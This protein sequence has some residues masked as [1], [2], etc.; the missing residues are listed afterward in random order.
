[1]SD[2]C[3]TGGPRWVNTVVPRP[4]GCLVWT[5]SRSSLR[6]SWMANGS[7]PSR[8]R[9]PWSGAEAA[10]RGLSSTAGARSGCAICPL[11]AGRWSWPGESD[12]AGAHVALV[13]FYRL[14]RRRRGSR[15]V[16]ACP[17]RQSLGGRDPCLPLDRGLFQRADRGREPAHQKVKRVG[18]GFRNFANYRLRLLLYC[19]VRWQTHRTARLR[20]RSRLGRERSLGVPLKRSLSRHLDSAICCRVAKPSAFTSHCMRPFTCSMHRP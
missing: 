17:H 1:M 19:G 3:K 6:T 15:T 18:H 4:L 14:G 13:R 2:V 9:R 16:A 10:E 7:S 8:P 5:A 12:L 11:V 20:G